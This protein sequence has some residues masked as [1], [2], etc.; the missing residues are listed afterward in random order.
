MGEPRG[1][2]RR[3][4]LHRPRG[5]GVTPIEQ[6]PGLCAALSAL[7]EHQAGV[8]VVA[9]MDR[10]GRDPIVVAMI[11]KTAAM[12]GAKVVSASGEGNGD[13]PADQ[14]I[15]GKRA[16]TADTALR[17]AAVEPKALEEL[18]AWRFS[19]RSWQQPEKVIQRSHV[20]IAIGPKDSVVVAF[21]SQQQ[22]LHIF[23]TGRPSEVALRVRTRHQAVAQRM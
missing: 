5:L 21:R 14:F 16:V 12:R 1:R 3:S 9:R 10:I 20:L 11:E 8:L 23:G 2:H 13:S 6:R 7:R 18:E 15:A 17:L 22:P 4:G 19:W